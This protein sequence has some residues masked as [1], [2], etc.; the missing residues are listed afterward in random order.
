MEPRAVGHLRLLMESR[1]LRQFS[2]FH[3]TV[4]QNGHKDQFV[5]EPPQLVHK[6]LIKPVTTQKKGELLKIKPL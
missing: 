3:K 2:F 4:L 1:P 6:S 5:F